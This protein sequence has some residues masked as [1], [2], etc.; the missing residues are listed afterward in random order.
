[1]VEV[2]AQTIWYASVMWWCTLWYTL[3]SLTDRRCNQQACKPHQRSIHSLGSGSTALRFWSWSCS[4][5][6]SL[7]LVLVG[8]VCWYG[9]VNLRSV[10]TPHRPMLGRIHSLFAPGPICSQELSS[11]R[12]LAN[13]LP[14]LFAPWLIR[15][16]AHSLPGFFAPW[17]IR[18][19][20]RNGQSFLSPGAKIRANFNFGYSN[21]PSVNPAHWYAIF[22]LTVL[23]AVLTFKYC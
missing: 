12:T 23:H 14:G 19:Q 3:C 20:E 8:L 1:M 21:F 17:N 4:C 5:N 18:S 2:K 9:P 6:L 11:N 22:A 13:S 10:E 16:L 15:S 7:G